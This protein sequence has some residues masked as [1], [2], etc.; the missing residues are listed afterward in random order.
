MELMLTIVQ[1]LAW[2][3]AVVVVVWVVCDA[4]KKGL[5]K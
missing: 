1:I 5:G 2:P 4:I 3:V